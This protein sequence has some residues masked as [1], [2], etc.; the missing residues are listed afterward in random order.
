MAGLPVAPRA[1]AAVKRPAKT[2]ERARRRRKR[3]DPLRGG[4]S[5]P[6]ASAIAK[7]GAEAIESDE[8]PALAPMPTERAI[9]SQLTADELR[10]EDEHYELEVCDRRVKAELVDALAKSR[11]ARL[12]ELLPELPRHRLKELC[13]AFGLDDSG[14]KKA[15]LAA[16]LAGSSAASPAASPDAGGGARRGARGK[17]AAPAGGCAE[18]RAARKASLVGRRHPARVDRQQRLQELHLRP[19]LPEAAVGPLRGGGGEAD[20]R[21]SVR[22]RGVGPTRTSTS[23]SCRGGRGGAPSKGRPATSA[24]R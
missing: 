10:A 8:E 1:P 3:R 11:K 12:D 17:I 24:R 9:L 21:G 16:R 22:Q 14:R 18:R 23:S 6:S 20:R 5:R 2:T 15:E 13:R 7:L 4:E 19:A